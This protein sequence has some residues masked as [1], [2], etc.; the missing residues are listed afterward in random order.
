MQLPAELNPLVAALEA[1]R[2]VNRLRFHLEQAWFGYG[3]H[4]RAASRTLG[5]LGRSV[6]S[7][8]PVV[9]R[10]E[11]REAVIR[12]FV[13]MIDQIVSEGHYLF[14]EGWT[15]EI[16]ADDLTDE[17]FRRAVTPVFEAIDV[18]R[19]QI[20]QRLDDRGLL[21][22]SLGELLD[23]GACPPEIHRFLRSQ[24]RI[25]DD[26]GDVLC[27]RSIGV[28]EEEPALGWHEDLRQILLELG[29]ALEIQPEGLVPEVTPEG[30]TTK[31][32]VEQ[33][34][35]KVQAALIVWGEEVPDSEV[36][37]IADDQNPE[38]LAVPQIAPIGSDISESREFFVQ[39][40]D[41]NENDKETNCPS[42]ENETQCITRRLH[43]EL[44][45]S[46]VIFDG[47]RYVIEDP[48]VYNAFVIIYD[49]TLHGGRVLGNA[50][51]INSPHKRLKRWLPKEIFSLIKG[52]KGWKGG[53]RLL[54][55]EQSAESR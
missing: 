41:D 39:A 22:F 18:V 17:D 30:M 42:L 5:R 10:R 32:L 33:I 12:P 52:K 27:G 46:A 19:E 28:G 43:F 49:K 53:Y 48:E 7:L 54:L 31:Q 47:H 6:R 15:V 24:R 21:V 4:R 11:F 1:G 50:L 26:P 2:L 34:D 9:D 8:V 23:Q 25:T 37:P 38:G 40:T 51:G 44:G 3:N 14:Y 29:A 55:P 20:S 45:G 36:L 35:L 16:S 13:G